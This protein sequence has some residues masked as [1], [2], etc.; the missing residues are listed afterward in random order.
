MTTFLDHFRNIQILYIGVFHGV[1]GVARATPGLKEL[2]STGKGIDE[3][4]ANGESAGK[5]FIMCPYEIH[6][7]C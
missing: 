7:E 1:A 4:L 6:S 2:P 5:I 3:G